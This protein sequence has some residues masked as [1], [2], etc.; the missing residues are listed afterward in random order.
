MLRDGP[1]HL[2]SMWLIV[3]LAILAL[4][5]LV[6]GTFAV[7]G[8]LLGRRAEREYRRPLDV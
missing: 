5:I 8:W 2:G 3:P 4:I 1:G 7:R 6:P